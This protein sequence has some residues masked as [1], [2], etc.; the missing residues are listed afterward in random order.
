MVNMLRSQLA[1]VHWGP[2]AKAS[3]VPE[4]LETVFMDWSLKPFSAGYHGWAPHYDMNDVMRQIR[5]PTQLMNDVDADLFIVGS[6]YS[7]DQAW[8]EG[9]FC[10]A[11]SVIT[12]FLDVDP[13]IDQ[14]NYPF[15]AH[16]DE[17]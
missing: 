8:V 4:P 7:N 11:E 5:K 3:L 16:G 2:G 13:I 9:A 15:I 12:E 17:D 14:S 1:R 10:T 6:A